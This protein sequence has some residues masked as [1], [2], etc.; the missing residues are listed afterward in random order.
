MADSG[1]DAIQLSPGDAAPFCVGAATTG[2]FY[3]FQEQAGR[4]VALILTEQLAAPG[5]PALVAAFAERIAGFA[6]LGGD[7]VLLTKGDPLGALSYS[8][9]NPSPVPVVI[10]VGDFFAKCRLAQHQPAVLV[11]DR[12]LRIAGIIEAADASVAARA[13]DCMALLPVE[14]AQEVVLPAPLL[15][16]PNLIERDLCR[17]LIQHFENGGYF[18]SGYA[19]VGPDGAPRYRID[20]AKKQRNDLLIDAGDPYFDMLRDLLIRRCGAEI[21][22]AF[23][24]DVAHLDRLLIARYDAEKGYFRRHRDNGAP[25]V[26]FRQFALTLNLNTEEYSGGHLVFPEHNPHRYRPPTGGGIV[27]STSLLH[28]ALPVTSGTR[29]VL[30]TF[31]HSDSAEAGRLARLAPVIAA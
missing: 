16:I 21:K 15:L 27:F 8:I 1:D 31:L 14:A 29:Y 26:A 2:A 4:P 9:A 25:N 6:A 28:E 23:Q 19:T 24:V 22:K 30:L 10:C 20:H 13:I 7:V 3:S 18:E 12:N 5:L 11:L 17:T